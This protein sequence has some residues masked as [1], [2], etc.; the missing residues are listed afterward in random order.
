MIISLKC[1]SKWFP[2]GKTDFAGRFLHPLEGGRSGVAP[3]VPDG[4]TSN[5]TSKKK[6]TQR[7]ERRGDAEV[8]VVRD[9]AS[10]R[11]VF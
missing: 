6:W 10:L 1:P 2:G 9:F 5:D 4:V 8:Q 11:Q 3:A 7:R